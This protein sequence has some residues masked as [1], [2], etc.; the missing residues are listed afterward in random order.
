MYSQNQKVKD[1]KVFDYN[2]KLKI[3]QRRISE[4]RVWMTKWSPF[5]LR[6]HPISEN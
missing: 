4:T 3:Y 2:I 1:F 6:N 5:S